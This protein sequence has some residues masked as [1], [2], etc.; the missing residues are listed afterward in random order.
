MIILQSKC[1]EEEKEVKDLEKENELKFEFSAKHYAEKGLFIIIFLIMI[2]YEK[3]CVYKLIQ[4]LVVCYLLMG[5]LNL[6]Y[7]LMT[8]QEWI[9]LIMIS[10]DS[11]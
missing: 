10:H 1:Q 9:I 4:V 3:N 7:C 8:T 2:Y 6:F 5:L 11:D